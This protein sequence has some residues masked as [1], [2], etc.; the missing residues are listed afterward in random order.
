M[1]DLA[2]KCCM[3]NPGFLDEKKNSRHIQTNASSLGVVFEHEEASVEPNLDLDP[4]LIV[5][6]GCLDEDKILREE[7]HKTKDTFGNE[8]LVP[9]TENHLTLVQNEIADLSPNICWNLA[10]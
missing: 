6:P 9:T 2:S 10:N 8:N 4:S 1:T 5:N 3:Q 7:G